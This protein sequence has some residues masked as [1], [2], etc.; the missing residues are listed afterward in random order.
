MF[1]LNKLVNDAKHSASARDAIVFTLQNIALLVGDANVARGDLQKQIEASTEA[2]A[3]SILNDRNVATPTS[4][5]PHTS[6]KRV[7]PATHDTVFGG[8]RTPDTAVDAPEVFD[9]DK[10][11]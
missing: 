8:P 1:T 4:H 5:T 7:A 9:V 10:P 3:D 2:L 6:H 11:L